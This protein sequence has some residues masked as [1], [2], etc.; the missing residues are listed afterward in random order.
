LGASY[1]RSERE[2]IIPL[3]SALGGPIWST[4]SRP[5]APSTRKMQS[6][7][8]RSQRRATRLIRGL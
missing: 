2:A 6:S 8:R 1:L 4:E 5:G 7:W 3:Y